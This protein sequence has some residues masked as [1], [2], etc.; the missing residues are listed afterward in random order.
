MQ[1]QNNQTAW[2]DGDYQYKDVVNS[3]NSDF[4]KEKDLCD[5]IE[6]NIVKFTTDI[7]GATY[8]SHDREY[9]LYRHRRS[10]GGNIRIDFLIETTDGQRI[11]I[12]CKHPFYK[13]EL[14]LAVGQCLGY[15]SQFEKHDK[16]LDKIFIVSTK[17]DDIVPS[18][19]TKFNLPI[20][21]VVMDKQKHLILKKC[22]SQRVI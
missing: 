21:F 22:Q 17:I 19:I 18:I 6:L 15:L 9:P 8:K 11:G 12:E 10:V 1:E 13:S 14:S 5:Y 20:E 4:K 3:I 7:V 16:E 2:I